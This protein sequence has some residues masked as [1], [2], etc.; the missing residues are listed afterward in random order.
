MDTDFRGPGDV[1]AGLEHVTP[2]VVAVDCSGDVHMLVWRGGDLQAAN[3]PDPEA[4]RALVALG[5][6][7]CRCIQLLSHWETCRAEPRVLTL[8]PRGHEPS[9]EPADQSRR[10]GRGMFPITTAPTGSGA[11]GMARAALIHTASVGVTAVSTGVQRISR[12]EGIEDPLFALLTVGGGIPR[13][14]VAT[15]AATLIAG[16]D[17]IHAGLLQAALY[18]RVLTGLIEWL[19]R[20]PTLELRIIAADAPRSLTRDA[21]GGLTAE[22]PLSWLTDVWAP[23]LV[24]VAGDF[25]LASTAG[26]AGGWDLLTVDPT[27]A[28]HRRTLTRR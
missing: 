27:L 20:A 23:E 2:T 1:T 11:S 21:N 28:I 13:R 7:P 16:D 19:G 15:V 12:P 17:P 10:P 8:G 18:G 14:L 25:V 5:G 6:E 3:H 9:L 4:E 22:L 26:D 24:T